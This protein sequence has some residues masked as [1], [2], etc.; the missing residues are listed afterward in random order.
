MNASSWSRPSPQ[1]TRRVL[2]ANLVGQ[3]G[4]VVT[5]G[6]VR[7]TG[8]GLGC[9]TWPQCEPGQFTPVRHEA[10]S[11]HPF[12]EFGN[13][14][15][16]GV[17]VVLAVAALWVV[18]R[19]PGRRRGL[20]LLAAVPLLGVLAQAVIGGLTVLV[21]L[22]PAWVGS[23]LL[24]SLALISASTALVL[25]ERAPDGPA[26]WAVG[27]PLRAGVLA[28]VPLAALVHTLGTVVTGSGPH[29]GDDDAAYRYALDPVAIT[30]AHSLA[31][32][33]FLTVLVAVAV[34]LGRRAGRVGADPAL[35]AGRRRT[36]ELLGLSLAQGAIGYLQYLLDLPVVL[37]GLHMLGASLLV[38][39]QTAQVLALR[40]RA[41]AAPTTPPAAPAAALAA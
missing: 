23:H 29:S 14:T 19:Q 4:I 2:V 12:V 26:R 10:A 7:L 39:A 6:A 3:V 33:A 8:S 15:L 34:A 36:A 31:V 9:S 40:P 25:R 5:G 32:W 13:R 20:R 28:L 22:H 17:L 16:T 27:G 21:D 11:F 35:L 30:R 37:V 1:W 24:V 38:V 41:S 18:W